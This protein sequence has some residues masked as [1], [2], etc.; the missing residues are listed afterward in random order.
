MHAQVRKGVNGSISKLAA[1]LSALACA[2]AV[3]LG[4]PDDSDKIIVYV[5][6]SAPAGGDGTSWESAFRDLQDAIRKQHPNL[7]DIEMRVA[8][9]VYT[10]DQGTGDRSMMFRF[11]GF[12]GSAVNF[13][14]LG[15]FG[16]LQS[17]TPDARDYVSTPTVLSGDLKGDD[18]GGAN[19]SD[20]SWYIAIVGAQQ[21]LDIDGFV[22]R[23]A[24]S[25][26]APPGSWGRALSAYLH[27][28]TSAVPTGT[29]SVTN[30]R[31]EDN[32]VEDGFGAGLSV[33]GDRIFVADCT[34]VRNDAKGG[35][36]GALLITNRAEYYSAIRNCVFESNT[37]GFGGAAYCEGNP[38]FEQCV[39]VGNAAEFQGG[40]LFGSSAVQSSLFL[41]NTAG[42]SGGAIAGSFVSISSST[43][44]ENSAPMGS[45]VSLSNGMPWITNSIFW[46]NPSGAGQTELRFV[47]S[48]WRGEI[49]YSV[50]QGGAS[51]IQQ[52]G[53]VTVP[54]DGIVS[55]DP[56]FRRP[57]N[58]ADEVADWGMWNYRLREGSA[59]VAIGGNVNEDLDGKEFLWGVHLQPDAGCY[60]VTTN[61]CQANL[62]Q[63]SAN[64]VDD[65]DFT[66]FLGAYELL[67]SP[68]ANPD[69]DL[70]LDGLVND[71]DFSLFAVAYDQMFCP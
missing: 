5:D 24:D 33:S 39:F 17:E 25:V 32:S 30:C 20:N 60:F 68:P 11:H 2:A 61:G 15:S 42:T 36:G 26:D 9:G 55:G 29:L 65:A 53:F 50:L 31:F 35:R 18:A 69:A 54:G 71:A 45:A 59:A 37:A 43:L 70:N 67:L 52:S 40:G 14:L 46:N 64:L 13:S 62:N 41:R 4:V 8:Q 6:K 3:A 49:K 28:E 22:V 47:D 16:G 7:K 38:A 66:V 27:P 10:P 48:L 21:R 44:T 56:L 58:P 1:G 51:A 34:F 19:R 12:L 57:S 63:D 23:G